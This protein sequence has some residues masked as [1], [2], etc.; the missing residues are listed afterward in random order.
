MNVQDFVSSF[1]A[2]QHGQDAANAL[3]N[4]GI[5]PA[6]AQEYLTHAAAAGHEHVE[7]HG[8]G[9]LGSHPGKSFFAAFAMGIVKG[10]GI[11]GALGDG[12]EGVIVGR[13]AEALA[14]R[15]GLDPN[16]ASTV[17]AAATPYVVAFIKSKLSG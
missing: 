1:L 7:E 3:A 16:T 17:A 10:D 5:D 14:S 4:Q 8:A 11:L 12:V 6:K 15:A 9:L 13:V 2:S